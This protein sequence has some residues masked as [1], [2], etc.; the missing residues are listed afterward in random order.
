M[1]EQIEQG[2]PFILGAAHTHIAQQQPPEARFA[3]TRAMLC[4]DAIEPGFFEA[5]RR[6]I[7]RAEFVPEM[8]ERVGDREIETPDRAGR[9]LSLALRRA[10]FM[11][12]I[13]AT[14]GCGSISS[15][16]GRVVQTRSGSSQELRWHD[17][18][19]DAR[20]RL[21]ITL[22]LSDSPYEGGDFE[23]RHKKTR[24]VLFRHRHT[25]PGSVLIFS[26]AADLEH[27]VLPVMSG[28]PRRVYAGWFV[29]EPAS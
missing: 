24:E 22:D 16:E 29:S 15:V 19:N 6:L 7:T 25:S 20:R 1:N 4:R 11:Q 3:Q 14:T 10:Q 18:L 12:W 13:S 28:G 9:A 27:R 21:A 26:I 5:I 23:L 17:D 2:V 8:V